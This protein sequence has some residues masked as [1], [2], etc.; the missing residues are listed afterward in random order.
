MV[1]ICGELAL[2]CQGRVS[3]LPPPPPPPLPLAHSSLHARSAEEM[4]GQTAYE[5]EYEADHS[6]EDLEEDEFGN[7]RAP[8]RAN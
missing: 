5:R 6:W 1:M 8:V 4:R 3:L 2:A 7:L